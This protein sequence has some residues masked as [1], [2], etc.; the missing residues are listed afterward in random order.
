MEKMIRGETIFRCSSSLAVLVSLD[1][2]P[3]Q[4]NKLLEMADSSLVL[5]IPFPCELPD[6]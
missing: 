5:G 6:D 2:G 4:P 1:D 3:G